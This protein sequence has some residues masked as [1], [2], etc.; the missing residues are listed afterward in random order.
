MAFDVGLGHPDL[1][2]GVVPVNGV[3]RPSTTTFYQRNGQ[4]LPFYAVVGEHAGTNFGFNRRLYEVW[5]QHGYASL[6]VA[7]KGRWSEFYPGEVP[8]AFDWMSRKKRAN[9]FPVLGRNFATG[10]SSEEFVSWRPADNRFY[11]VSVEAYNDKFMNPEFGRTTRQPTPAA[12]QAEI[13][14]DNQVIVNTRGVR[15]ATVWLGRTWD[16]ATGSKSMVDPT[17]PV[18]LR[19]NRG[20]GRTVGVTPSLSVMLEDLFTRGDRQRLFYAAIDLGNLPN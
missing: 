6:L 16:P 9:G 7:Y 18:T 17:K 19:V 2:A 10:E 4:Y 8:F 11:W 3:P 13:R 1:F 14:E 12:V 15:R 20:S 5:C